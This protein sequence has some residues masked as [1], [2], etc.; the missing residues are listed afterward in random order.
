MFVLALVP[1]AAQDSL[2]SQTQ[3]AYPD[4]LL[5]A[6]PN[7]VEERE[8]GLNLVMGARDPEVF[9]LGL[10]WLRRAAERG[11]RDTQYRLAR[12]LL[13][14]PLYWATAPEHS[15]KKA[16]VS[17]TQLQEWREE[18]V[19]WLRKSAEAGH[20]LARCDLA[21]H[22]RKGDYVPRN[23][24]DAIFWYESTIEDELSAFLCHS[25][26]KLGDIYASS[27]EFEIE[28]DLR[29]AASWYRKG[30]EAGDSDCQYLLGIMYLEAR[31]VP[32]DDKEAA[33]W[34]QLSAED[35]NPKAATNVGLL[36]Y[37]GRG[38]PKSLSRAFDY[39][40]QAALQDEIDAQYNVGLSL[41]SGAGVT[42][43]YRAAFDWLSHAAVKGFP[44][45]QY[46]LA[47]L[48]Y[49]GKGTPQDFDQAS[50]WLRRAAEQG[51]RQAQH[52]LAI[53][54]R[55][56]HGVKKDLLSAHIWA[57]VAASG[58]TGDAFTVYAELR[59]E[60]GSEMTAVQLR[61]AQRHAQ[62]WKRKTWEAISEE[63]SRE[64]RLLN[65]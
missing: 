15:A 49:E 27:D 56:G 14:Y 4:W 46:L 52:L 37:Y 45:A 21:D 58:E 29:Q 13:H 42:Q 18:G 11:D 40:R 35:G 63:E 60:I 53:K 6:E 51:N 59:D 48:Y 43:D 38:V 55:D 26:R 17:T 30:S 34:L 44:D 36:Y 22:S 12:A 50:K 3:R 31:G 57:N 20:P 32:Q 8:I 64:K 1:S 19:L 62:Q 7:A 25:H 23:L 5:P 61:T 47:I 24:K 9:R 28:Q 2:R 65:K 39:F 16:E 33:K 41:Y 10:G 54:F